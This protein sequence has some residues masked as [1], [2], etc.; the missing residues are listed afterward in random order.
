MK[1]KFLILESYFNLYH[2]GS[3]LFY[4]YLS[5]Y[6]QA[7]YIQDSRNSCHLLSTS[8][9]HQLFVGEEKTNFWCQKTD[10]LDLDEKFFDKTEFFLVDSNLYFKYASSLTRNYSS[11]KVDK[12]LSILIDYK[13]INWIFFVIQFVVKNFKMVNFF[14]NES[15]FLFEDDFNYKN[16][17]KNNTLYRKFIYEI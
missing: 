1:A 12:Q 11:L 4:N 10:N 9:N 15:L 17:S 6:F 2:Y 16:M 3:S 14:K 13:V 7:N 5:E 8:A